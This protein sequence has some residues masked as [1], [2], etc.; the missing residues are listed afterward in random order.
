M[1]D[2]PA[3]DSDVFRCLAAGAGSSMRPHTAATS[4]SSHARLL[5]MM[6]SANR[7]RHSGQENMD[8]VHCLPVAM[9]QV[10]VILNEHSESPTVAA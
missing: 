10:S 3:A 6:H 1:T 7:M 9:Q 4:S 2:A 5:L 8:V